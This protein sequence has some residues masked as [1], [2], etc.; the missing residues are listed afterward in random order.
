MKREEKRREQEQVCS[1]VQREFTLPLL[2]VQFCFI[3]VVATSPIEIESRE[4][5]PEAIQG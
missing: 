2:F 1:F 4:V 5:A 3:E